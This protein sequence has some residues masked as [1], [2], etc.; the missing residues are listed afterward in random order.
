MIVFIYV[1]VLFGVAAALRIFTPPENLD[2]AYWQWLVLLLLIT[3]HLSVGLASFHA[4]YVSFSNGLFWILAGGLFPLL[5]V[6]HWPLYASITLPGDQLLDELTALFVILVP[7]V[8]FYLGPLMAAMNP[9]R[10]E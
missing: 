10:R 3:T 5:Y 6:V 2:A 1:A 8:L 7:T 9:G 4:R